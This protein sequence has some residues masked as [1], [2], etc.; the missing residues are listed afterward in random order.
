MYADVS[1]TCDLCG[2][3]V[4]N[5]VNHVRMS[6]DADHGPQGRYPEGWNGENGDTAPSISAESTNRSSEDVDETP[7]IDL[8]DDVDQEDDADDLETIT[9]DDDPADASEYECGSCGDRLE[10]HQNECQ[11]GEA[12]MWRAPAA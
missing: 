10:Y 3:E 2:C 12:P 8:E 9:F 11:C 7:T 1:E 4:S 6:S 5:L